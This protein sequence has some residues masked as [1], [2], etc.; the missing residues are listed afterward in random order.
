MTTDLFKVTCVG[1]WIDAVPELGADYEGHFMD[2]NWEVE[3]PF[4]KVRGI[5]GVCGFAMLPSSF[6]VTAEEAENDM[7]FSAHQHLFV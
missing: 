6:K 7:M 5:V 4:G 2:S 1:A 3:D